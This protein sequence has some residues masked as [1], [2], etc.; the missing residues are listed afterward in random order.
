M[1]VKD[2]APA[3]TPKVDF[4]SSRND[5]VRGGQRQ[6]SGKKSGSGGQG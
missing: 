3:A 6:K 1:T 5:P 4:L 2:F